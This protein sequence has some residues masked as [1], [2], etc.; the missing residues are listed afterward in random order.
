M[1]ISDLGKPT[2]MTANISGG[3]AS[4]GKPTSVAPTIA[5]T[6]NFATDWLGIKNPDTYFSDAF[7][8]VKNT[9]L[10]PIQTIKNV[11]GAGIGALGSAVSNVYE[12]NKNILLGGHKPMANRVADLF[13]AFG[14]DAGLV[15]SPISAAFAAAEQLPVLKEA[16]DVLQ[17]PFAATGKIGDFAAE[18]F[19]D[20]LPIDQQSKDVL[21]PAFG[22]LGT[23]AGQLLLGGKVM[24]MVV[25]GV[26]LDKAKIDEVVNE[27]KI[28]TEQAKTGIIKSNPEIAKANQLI[29]PTLNEQK[30]VAIEPQV[31]SGIIPPE[32][33]K[34]SGLA[35]SIE[36]KAI[37]DNLTKGFKDLAEYNSSTIKEQAK[38]TTDL[39]NSDIEKTRA[40]IRGDE[41]LPEKIRGSSLIL[42]MEDYLKKNPN[43]DI[44]YELANSPLVSKVSQAG[45]E[46]GL[47]QNRIP[48][49]YTAK[50]Q[51]VRKI[52]EEK[53]SETKKSETIKNIKKETT[54]NNL[55][56]EET[57]WSSFLDDITC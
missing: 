10:H 7:N 17:M 24:D 45:S 6:S 13:H 40:I 27:T 56:V 39:I 5:S 4:L 33:G 16:A 8:Q 44:A 57:K 43:E 34:I 54:K 11:V 30:G 20:Y 18:K 28:Q 50:L 46:L 23:L 55:S 19:V 21:K 29:E 1:G 49:S 37:E 14:A 31:E 26:G 42:G 48:D 32:T 38:M 22:E 51:E 47:M 53:I 52:R 36:V 35:K 25:K 15:F 2:T 9:I 41:L 3:I 12:A